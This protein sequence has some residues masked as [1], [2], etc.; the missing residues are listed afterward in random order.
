MMNL[1]ELTPLTNEEFG[2]IIAA[3]AKLR[4]ANQMAKN[5]RNPIF[6]GEWGNANN[7]LVDLI[8]KQE[9]SMN[10]L[11]PFI[12]ILKDNGLWIDKPDP[13][14]LK[15]GSTKSTTY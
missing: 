1:K 14:D 3:Y 13:V 12:N 9:E 4:L 11:A 7:K 6:H 8:D 5:L 10:M 2:K 15:S